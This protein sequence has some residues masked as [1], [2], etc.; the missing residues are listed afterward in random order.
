MKKSPIKIKFKT[1]I[2]CSL[3]KVIF[4]KGRCKHCDGVY[5]AKKEQAKPRN[6]PDKVI[7]L[8][9]KAE[10]QKSLPEL[11]ILLDDWFSRFIRLR[12]THKG[13]VKC[14]TC[15]KQD[16]PKNM[17]N[18]HY[19]SRKYKSLRWDETNCNGQCPFCNVLQKGNYTEYTL[20]MDRKY[21][22][23]IKELLSIKKH[24][25]SL[26][27]RFEMQMLIEHYT[28]KVSE[29]LIEKNIEKWW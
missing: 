16:E 12:D 11:T 22:P 17:Q 6:K 8:V 19:E 5:R 2:D 10:K 13:K 7:K 4:S 28:K 23:Q 15:S 18:G 24:N 27:G 9:N 29:L 25:K 14:C 21:G 20:F 26:L 3:P 1:C